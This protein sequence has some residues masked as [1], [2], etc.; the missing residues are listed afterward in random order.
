MNASPLTDESVLSGVS[1]KPFLIEFLFEPVKFELVGDGRPAPAS[2]LPG[3]CR[4]L[5]SWAPLPRSPNGSERPRADRFEWCLHPKL[6]GPA[7]LV[8]LFSVAR[9]AI[10][11]PLAQLV[12]GCGVCLVE[13]PMA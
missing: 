8:V 5:P 6:S 3:D 2:T 7:E 11:T 13:D 9:R 10:T 4:S 12:S 1:A